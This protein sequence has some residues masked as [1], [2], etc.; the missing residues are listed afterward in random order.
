MSAISNITQL[1]QSMSCEEMTITLLSGLVYRCHATE[2]EHLPQHTFLCVNWQAWVHISLSLQQI[3]LKL[4][5]F[6][7]SDMIK[8]VVG[9]ILAERL[10]WFSETSKT[11]RSELVYEKNTSLHGQTSCQLLLIVF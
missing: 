9:C 10:D 7:K 6:T 4:R 1:I 5:M 2:K 11:I 8:Q 3:L